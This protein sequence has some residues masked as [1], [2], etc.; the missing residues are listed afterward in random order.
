MTGISWVGLTFNPP[1]DNPAITAFTISFYSDSGGVP[2]SVL[3]S[4]TITGNANQTANG[5]LGGFPTFTYSASLS[6]ALNAS[7]GTEYWVSIVPDLSFPP[8]WGWSNGLGGD[9]Q[10][11]QVFFGSG[12]SLPGDRAFTLTGDAVSAV[13]EPSTL[14]SAGI[15]GLFGLG[16]ALRRR[17]AKAIAWRL[18]RDRRKPPSPVAPPWRSGGAFALAPCPRDDRQRYGA[19]MPGRDPAGQLARLI[20]QVAKDYGHQDRE[21]LEEG[22]KDAMEGRQPRW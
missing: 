4:E 11:Y 17:K 2:G 15:A 14:A 13:P 18:R 12:S 20:D 7:A 10:S 5:S 19:N 16:F 6:T 22:V 1:D 3:E 9:G 21:A 8:Q